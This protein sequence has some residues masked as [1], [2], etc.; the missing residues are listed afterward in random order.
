MKLTDDSMLDLCSV[1]NFSSRAEIAK[2][3]REGKTLLVDH[4]TIT[5]KALIAK[6]ERYRVPYLTINQ[7]YVV[8][9]NE[10]KKA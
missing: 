10:R 9:L 8:E 1:L 3:I 4:T 2:E 7:I 6:L 5:G